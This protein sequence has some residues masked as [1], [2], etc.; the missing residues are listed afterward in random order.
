MLQNNMFPLYGRVYAGCKRSLVSELLEELKAKKKNE[1]PDEQ[2]VRLEQR[3]EPLFHFV[4]R[5]A[6]P[7]PF[8]DVLDVEMSETEEAHEEIVPSN[9]RVTHRPDRDEL[10]VCGA[11]DDLTDLPEE[12]QVN[13]SKIKEALHS[14]DETAVRTA[15]LFFMVSARPETVAAVCDELETDTIA[16]SKMQLLLRSFAELKSEISLINGVVFVKSALLPKVSNL[17]EGT[18]ARSL[19]DSIIA[20]AQDMPHVTVEGLL[21]PLVSAESMGKTQADVVQTLIKE[22]I[23]KDYAAIC[24]RRMLQESRACI[25]SLVAFVHTIVLKRGPLESV[26]AELVNWLTS[27]K[28]ERSTDSKFSKLLMDFVSFYGSQMSPACLDSVVKVVNVNRTLLKK[29]I[30]N[31]LTKLTT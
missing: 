31:M 14:C 7:E 23:P 29:P 3:C 20:F 22:G 6:E 28:D 30:Q 11:P 13:I 4:P 17:E 12:I 5:E 26:S 18:T 2:L 16:D 24:L 9:T 19:I 27:V 15:D 8:G 25:E 21:V 1:R 10:E